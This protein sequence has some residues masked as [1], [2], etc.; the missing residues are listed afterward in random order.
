MYNTVN[1]KT[2]SIFKINDIHLADTLGIISPFTTVYVTIDPENFYLVDYKNFK[3]FDSN[4]VPKHCKR[5]P[6]GESQLN[7]Y[8]KND[9]IKKFAAF[10]FKAEV[11]FSSNDSIFIK[12]QIESLEQ[13]LKHNSIQQLQMPDSL[14]ECL[15]KYGYK[16]Y[17]ITDAIEYFYAILVQYNIHSY[18][19][20]FIFDMATKSLSFYE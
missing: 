6:D 9:L 13:T 19:R 2:K 8:V 12:R 5:F 15:K 11:K 18:Y 1:N 7:N 20:F 4:I 10:P 16:Q 3:V 14:Y 17:L